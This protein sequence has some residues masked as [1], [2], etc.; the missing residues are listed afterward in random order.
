M[1][2][3]FSSFSIDPVTKV[4]C[5]D[6]IILSCDERMVLLLVELIEAYPESCSHDYL[7]KKL[8]PDTVV[9]TLSLARVVSDSRKFFCEAGLDFC[10]I[11]TVHGRGYKLSHDMATRLI[12]EPDLCDEQSSPAHS[13]SSLFLRDL[14]AYTT[15]TASNRS[16]ATSD[17]FNFLLNKR[18]LGYYTLIFFLLCLLSLFLYSE[19]GVKPKQLIIG[20][21]ASVKARLLWVDD[22]PVN[23]KDEKDFFLSKQIAVYNVTSTQDAMT[24]L[25]LY[26]YDA[27]IT[28]MGRG[29]DPLAGLKFIVEVREKLL[30]T[31]VYFY[32]IMPSEAL[33]KEIVSK[34]GNGIAV[35]SDDLYQLI[36]PE[37][38]QKDYKLN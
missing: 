5:S 11:T 28:D 35:T 13:E 26:Q 22:N 36:L 32:T 12:R 15:R 27:I 2:Y 30:S 16:D 24:L 10:V 3:V 8:W 1:R 21:P 9:S 4:L 38:L 14:G 18:S 6:K 37:L 29:D 19:H 31:P 25:N 34:G 23:N 7:L 20:E 33:Q 17:K